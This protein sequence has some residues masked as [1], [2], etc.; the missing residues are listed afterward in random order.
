M[1]NRYVF[2]ITGRSI[3]PH[4][5]S[6]AANLNFLLRHRFRVPASWVIIWSALDDYAADQTAL[7]SVI[8]RE[9]QTIIEPGKLYAVRSSASVEDHGARSCAGLFQSFLN[10]R[11]LDAITDR[12]CRVW[13]SLNSFEFQVYRQNHLP[14]GT[15][16]HMAVIIQEMVPARA[17]GVVF[18]KNPLTGLS[19]TIIETGN[20]DGQQQA[21]ARSNPERW[22]SKWG[23]WLEKPEQAVIDETLA[24]TIVIETARIANCYKQP[25]DCEWAWDGRLLYYL[26]VRPITRLDIPIY[27]NRIAREMLPGVIKPLVWSV[28]TGLINQVW[29]GILT[30][31]TGDHDY[32]P[33]SLTGYFY[34]RAYFNM[35]VFGRVFDW[36]GLPG[37]ALELLLGLEQ[38]GPDKPHMKP[39]SGVV[40][41]LP[42]LIGFALSFAG[43]H[44]RL[45]RLLK[46]KGA[47]YQVLAERLTENLSIEDC[48]KQAGQILNETKS[49]AY[50]N[51]MIPMLAMM[52]HRMLT[53][54]LKKRGYDARLLE[55]AGARE[56]AARFNPQNRLQIL[57]DRYFHPCD[58]DGKPMGSL[59]PAQEEQLNHDLADFLKRY[60]HFSDSGNDCSQV[61][62]RETPGLIR[63]MIER[64]QQARPTVGEALHFR[65][66]QLPWL[67]RILIGSIY[68]RTSRFAVDREAISSLYTYGYGHFRTCFIRLGQKLVDQGLLSDREDIYYLYWQELTELAAGCIEPQHDRVARRKRE[69]A[70]YRDAS[71]PELIFGSTPPPVGKTLPSAM[72][73]IPTSLGLYTGPARILHGIG[74][75]DC[76]QEG[77]VLV[78]PY[79][80]VGWTPL[81]ARARAVVAESG[82]IL[83]HSSIVAREY[84]IPAVVSVA[85]ACR[86]VNGTIVTVNG[87]TGEIV[88]AAEA[89]AG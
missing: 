56:A 40:M 43:I 71:L 41:R 7:L 79:S 31:L 86:L 74:E 26:Q 34:Y 87:Y 78:I 32:T 48:L 84:G 24:R 49:V 21:N 11:G 83:S 38:D 65:D 82:G 63:Q 19:E 2:P 18:S 10:I 61:P 51:I 4:A 44:G 47:A 67:Q 30:R 29:V 33:E 6:K 77:D 60:G 23:N 45:E 20:G 5:G 70:E 58:P 28:N 46:T 62:W 13:D 88:V 81:F 55:L 52:H 17:S 25:V 89:S 14:A 59:S 72:R 8:R 85:G 35:A 27:S 68:R 73:G 15:P 69:I 3:H 39:G 76:L 64:E 80:D 66:L 50:Y 22:V 75:Y 36:L 53:G 42:R 37:E 54:L 16:A 1:S 9:L 12:I 57:H